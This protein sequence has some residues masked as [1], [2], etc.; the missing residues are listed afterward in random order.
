[1]ISNL[2]SQNMTTINIFKSK[3]TIRFINRSKALVIPAIFLLTLLLSACNPEGEESNKSTAVSK[4]STKDFVIASKEIDTDIDIVNTTNRKIT[5]LYNSIK[6]FLIKSDSVG[7]YFRT[8]CMGCEPLHRYKGHLIFGKQLQIFPGGTSFSNTELPIQMTDTL[9]SR[10]DGY[11][12]KT[13]IK[14]QFSNGKGNIQHI[15]QSCNDAELKKVTLNYP[16]GK[17]VINNVLNASFF[18]YD[19]NKD[20]VKEQFIL[21]NRNCTQELAIIQILQK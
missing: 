7:R 20:G 11:G 16:N 14:F 17:V 6:N 3:N 15:K 18:E 5:V 8:E 4:P 13:T 19:L 21:A 10:V 12:M 2:R 1:M 9:I